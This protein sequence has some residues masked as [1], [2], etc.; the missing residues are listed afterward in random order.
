M[1]PTSEESALKKECKEITEYE[2][3]TVKTKARLKQHRLENNPLNNSNHQKVMSISPA[4]VN[5]CRKNIF[6][7]M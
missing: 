2:D 5:L 6:R 1:L 3:P 7:K 4:Q